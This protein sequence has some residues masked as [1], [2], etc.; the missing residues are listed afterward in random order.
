MK[1]QVFQ[2]CREWGISGITRV[3]GFLISIPTIS[4][5]AGKGNGSFRDCIFPAHS[6]SGARL[7]N[8]YQIN[9]STLYD[10]LFPTLGKSSH[11]GWPNSF[12]IK[13]KYPSP[14]KP[15][16]RALIILWSPIP[17][18]ITGV[19]GLKLL[20]FVYISASIIQNARVL[21]PTKAWSCD[22]A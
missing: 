6:N 13:F 17:L 18:S 5:L 14:P 16:T 4:R 2:I 20:I 11:S 21:S 19:L 7:Q 8:R 22:S 1:F 10:S 15:W 3:L 9:L 12:P